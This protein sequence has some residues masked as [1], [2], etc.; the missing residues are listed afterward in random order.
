MPIEHDRIYK[1]LTE[2]SKETEELQSIVGQHDDKILSSSHLMKSCKY[3]IIVITEAIA[4]ALQHILA[5]KYRIPANG[6]AEILNKSSQSQILSQE[7]VANLQPF[8][9]FRNMLVHHYWRV[10]DRRFLR[11]LREGIDDFRQFVREITDQIKDPEDRE[12]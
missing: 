6:Y 1:F 4:A 10:D 9:R 2:I 7:L 8:V 12:I 3:S 5:K 11:N